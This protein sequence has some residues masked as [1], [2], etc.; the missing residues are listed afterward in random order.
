MVYIAGQGGVEVEEAPCFVGNASMGS[1]PVGS[2]V[3]SP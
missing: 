3:L 1:N 2:Y